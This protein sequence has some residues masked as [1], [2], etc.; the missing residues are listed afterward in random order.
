MYIDQDP[1]QLHPCGVLRVRRSSDGGLCAPHVTSTHFLTHLHT[2][3]AALVSALW[4]SFLI[5]MHTEICV[6]WY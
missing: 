4:A 1:L 5:L 2:R 6:E 3:F